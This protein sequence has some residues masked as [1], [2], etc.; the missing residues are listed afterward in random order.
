MTAFEPI[1][2]PQAAKLKVRDFMLLNDAR[3]FA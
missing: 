2:V 1:N 3:A